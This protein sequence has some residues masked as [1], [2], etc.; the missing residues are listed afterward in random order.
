MSFVGK[1]FAFG[2]DEAFDNGIRAY[3]K[4]EFD[5]AADHFRNSSTSAMDP[6]LRERARSYVAGCLGKLARSAQSSR[7]FELA[8]SLLTE[9]T[10]IR[11]GFADLWHSMAINCR[12]LGE[13]KDALEAVDRALELNPGY[14]LAL[15][16]KGTVLM[17]SGRTES[18]A[19]LVQE[20]VESDPR[21]DG[22]AFRAGLEALGQGDTAKAIDEFCQ[23]SAAKGD[24]TDFIA[25]G[26]HH[27]KSGNWVGAIEMYSTA[28]EYAPGYSDVRCRLGQALMETGELDEACSQL[29][30]AIAGNP[31]YAEA[32]ALL[33][34]AKR[35]QGDEENALAAFRQAL[36][37]DPNHPIA[38]QEILYR[39]G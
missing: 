12:S 31:D 4:S 18:G 8:A 35:R 7:D 10:K 5:A 24:V 34:V 9:A 21:L 1:W 3:E 15:V 17:R 16:T 39:R 25:N 30:R 22:A 20:A 11:P 6:A 38:R 29:Q 26:D 37:I 19:Q 13:H 14:A 23:I 33:G 32:Y 2:Q 27:A 28:L 36:A